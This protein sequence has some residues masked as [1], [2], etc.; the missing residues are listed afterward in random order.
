TTAGGSARTLRRIRHRR[1]AVQPDA[2]RG[3]ASGRRPDRECTSGARAA[4]RS[5]G[6]ARRR[7]GCSPAHARSLSRGA[8]ELPRRPRQRG[9]SLRRANATRKAS[10]TKPR[11]RRRDDSRAWR[12]LLR[13][14]NDCARE[15]T[16][17]ESAAPLPDSN[18]VVPSPAANAAAASPPGRASQ[19]NHNRKRLL[20]AMAAVVVFGALAAG[21]WWWFD[22]RWHETTDDA[23]V[24]GNLV[25]LTPQ[26]S[27]IVVRINADDTALVQAGQPVVDLDPADTDTALAQA[28]AGLAQTVRRVAQLFANVD[29]QRANVTL[30]QAELRRAQEDLARRTGLPDARA[31]SQG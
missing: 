30:R 11:A 3:D 31:V 5:G 20:A 28:K 14:A 23:Y 18:A 27:G 15:P 17:N 7:R 24:R 8:H 29:A 25:Q 2:R 1:G 21:A 9:T 10:G 19:P 4:Y 22:A 13:A 6:R 26:I 16:M 12:R